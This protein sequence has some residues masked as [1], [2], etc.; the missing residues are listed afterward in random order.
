[1]SE[2]EIIAAVFF[3]GLLILAFCGIACVEMTKRKQE[4]E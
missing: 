2:I 1:M 3:S 4:A